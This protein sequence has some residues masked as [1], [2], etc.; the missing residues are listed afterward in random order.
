MLGLSRKGQDR[1]RPPFLDVLIGR[2]LL[3]RNS[4]DIDI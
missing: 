3:K 2:V 4:Y 1:K